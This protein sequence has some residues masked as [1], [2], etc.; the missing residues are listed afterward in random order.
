MMGGGVQTHT[1]AGDPI[2]LQMI[3]EKA[4]KMLLLQAF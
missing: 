4:C 2:L 3:Q 1:F